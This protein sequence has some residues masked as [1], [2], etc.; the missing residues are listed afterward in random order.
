[1][2]DQYLK[3]A[4]YGMPTISAY[5]AAVGLNPD[6]AEGLSYLENEVLGLVGRF[7]PLQSSNTM[8]TSPTG[9]EGEAGR[10]AGEVGEITDEGEKTQ[11][12]Q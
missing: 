12:K 9:S 3:A 5:C 8:S 4:T 7:K 2:A 11:E 6:D 10:P 1:M